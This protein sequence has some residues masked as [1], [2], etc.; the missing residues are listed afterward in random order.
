[1]DARTLKKQLRA[2]MLLQYE[3]IFININ[4]DDQEEYMASIMGYE[5][6]LT[7]NQ[8][9]RFRRVM[10]TIVTEALARAG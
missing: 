2:E 1:M 3:G 8:K 7:Q 10:R 4:D 6:P 5:M 9:D